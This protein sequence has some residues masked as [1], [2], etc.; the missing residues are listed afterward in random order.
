MR[1]NL[2]GKNQRTKTHDRLSSR[3]ESIWLVNFQGSSIWFVHMFL[4][5][6]SDVI[7]HFWPL[8]AERTNVFSIFEP[9]S[10]PHALTLNTNLENVFLT[11]DLT[12]TNKQ[13]HF[14]FFRMT[15]PSVEGI[16]LCEW[17]FRLILFW[18]KKFL[19]KRFINYHIW[20]F[21][22]KSDTCLERLSPI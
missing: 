1:K 6:Y 16:Y 7:M 20:I 5:W 19:D 13:T 14:N 9:I 4:A 2:I 22:S 11:F 8:K 12:Q 10:D 21:I 18:Q 3:C 15:L 17:N